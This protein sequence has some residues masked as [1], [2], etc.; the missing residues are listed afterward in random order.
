MS[1]RRRKSC[2]AELVQ[3]VR[4]EIGPVAAFKRVHLVS[5]LP[6]TRS[7]KILRRNIRQIADGE[8]PKV[9]AT[10]EDHSVLDEYFQLFEEREEKS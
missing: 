4:R 8:E 7:G 5:K 6:K 9:P 2:D 1:A 3:D 10:I